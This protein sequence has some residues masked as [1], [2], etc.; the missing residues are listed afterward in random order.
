MLS[1]SELTEIFHIYNLF[2]KKFWGQHFLVD[3]NIQ[4][5]II[6]V[7]QLSKRDTVLEIGPGLGALTEELCRKTRFVYAVEKDE[8]FCKILKERLR[9]F[10][11][12]ELINT[13]I[14][15]FP[16]PHQEHSSY[17]KLKVIGNLPYYIST[18]IISYLI[19]NHEYID[20]IYISLQKELAQRIVARAGEKSYGSLT[21]FVNFYA[22][23]IILFSIKRNCFFPRPEVDSCFLKIEIIKK[24]RTKKDIEKKIFS[25]VRSSFQNR[26]KKIINALLKSKLGYKREELMIALRKAKINSLR[27]PET[28]SIEDFIALAECL[29]SFKKH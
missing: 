29:D 24:P 26:R 9:S 1:L 22:K 18:P 23:P 8:A 6:L 21:V 28:L 7:C 16:F 25:I 5:K 20:S 4:K 10:K 19:E 12:L 2:P 14:L 3:K 11:N 17:K 15:K 13:D 27:R